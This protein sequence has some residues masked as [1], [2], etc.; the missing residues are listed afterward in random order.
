[1]TRRLRSGTYNLKL[2]EPGQ[3]A[4]V[5][6]YSVSVDA[7]RLAKRVGKSA[8]ASRDDL[9]MLAVGVGYGSGLQW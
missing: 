1:M 2:V 9:S 8:D 5:A 6:G 3:N 7:G 4:T